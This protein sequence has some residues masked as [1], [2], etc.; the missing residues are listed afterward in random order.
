MTY[1]Q[2]PYK[3]EL[4]DQPTYMEAYIWCRVNLVKGLWYPDYTKPNVLKFT[5]ETDAVEVFMR[6]G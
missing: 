4:R 2:W 3:I 6:F 5:S 1:N